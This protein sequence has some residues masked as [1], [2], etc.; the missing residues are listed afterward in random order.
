[1][2]HL[3]LHPGNLPVVIGVDEVQR[4]VKHRNDVKRIYHL[5]FMREHHAVLVSNVALNRERR[6]KQAAVRLARRSESRHRRR[7]HR[8]VLGLFLHVPLDVG[9]RP[10]GKMLFQVVFQ[11]RDQVALADVPG[12][13]VRAQL[14]RARLQA[15]HGEQR[16]GDCARQRSCMYHRE[17]PV[18]VIGQGYCCGLPAFISSARRA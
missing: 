15:E 11:D 10:A 2:R 4:F 12:I 9:L 18:G 5:A 8:L 13:A 14:S 16:A 3:L 17:A 7:A 6:I 1:M